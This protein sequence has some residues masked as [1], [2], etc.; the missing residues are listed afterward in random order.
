[1]GVRGIMHCIP[2]AVMAHDIKMPRQYCRGTNP[3]Q[4]DE[5]ESEEE[6]NV[7]GGQGAVNSG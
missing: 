5:E 2:C 6:Q 1:M 7:G 4:Q 3:T